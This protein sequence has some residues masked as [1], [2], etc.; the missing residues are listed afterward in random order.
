MSNELIKLQK[1]YSAQCQPIDGV[2][3]GQTP[4]Q[5]RYGI[6]ISTSDNPAWNVDIDLAGTPLEGTAIP[7]Y[8]INN[9]DA[10]WVRCHIIDNHYY[11]IGDPSKLTVILNYFFQF[12][13][14]R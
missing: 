3:S 12:Q 8:N 5:D 6:S 14:D 11:G 2:L 13:Q 7:A 9:G 4:W 1:W 10:D